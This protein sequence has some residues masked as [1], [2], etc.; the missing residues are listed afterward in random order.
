MTVG[1][2]IKADREKTRLTQIELGK[3]VF[4]SISANAAQNKLL[5]IEKGKQLP[6]TDELSKIAKV[7]GKN[8]TEYL[9]LLKGLDKSLD[10]V[11]QDDPGWTFSHEARERYGFLEKCVKI[12]N[13]EAEKG[14]STQRIIRILIK[15]LEFDLMR[16]DDET[17]DEISVKKKR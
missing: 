5:R 7:L 17:A 15:A 16:Q 8:V 3:I 6:K 11:F 1:E 2:K 14:R 12:V 4:P 9:K 13:E 10:G